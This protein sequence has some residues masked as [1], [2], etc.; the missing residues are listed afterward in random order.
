MKQIWLKCR[1]GTLVNLNNAAGLRVRRRPILAGAEETGRVPL[2]PFELLAVM[3][4]GLS[5]EVTVGTE[6]QCRYWLRTLQDHVGNLGGLIILSGIRAAPGRPPLFD[7]DPP[8]AR[9]R[10]S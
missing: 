3:A 10:S 2:A 7:E 4:P 1:D 9:G 8:A 5:F 6:E